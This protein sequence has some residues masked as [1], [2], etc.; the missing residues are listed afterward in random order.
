MKIL[1]VDNSFWQYF[2]KDSFEKIAQN[3]NGKINKLENN[4]SAEEAGARLMEWRPI[5][6]S[7]DIVN[8]DDIRTNDVFK[9]LTTIVWYNQNYQ[10]GKN[11]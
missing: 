6:G 1:S 3:Y 11:E 8:G 4:C 5:G 7:C 2:N 9:L 10:G